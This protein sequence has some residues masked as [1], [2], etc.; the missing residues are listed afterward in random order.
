MIL[1]STTIHS[2]TCEE[3]GKL[4]QSPSHHDG[5]RMGKGQGEKL[6]E[7]LGT[8]LVGEAGG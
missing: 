6:M 3:A 7:D 5:S 4:L 8:L 1:K 2:L